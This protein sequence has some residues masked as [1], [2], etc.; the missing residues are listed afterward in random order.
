MGDR[1]WGRNYHF[2]FAW[3]FLVNGLVYV[4][5][6]VATGRFRERLV[7]RRD[8]LSRREP[9]GGIVRA[10][11]PWRLRARAAATSYGALQKLSYLLLLV[12]Y[13]PLMTLTGLAQSPGFTAAMP[14]LLD[15]FGGRQSARTLHTVGTV[16][17]VLFVVVHVRGSA[18]GRRRQPHPCDDHRQ[19]PVARGGVMSKPTAA[20][21]RPAR[22]RTL[23]RRRL[24]VQVPALGALMAAG[25]S[26][27]VYVPPRTSAG[28]PR[29]RR[30]R[31]H[32]EHEPAAAPRPAAGP[33]VRAGGH[34]P[35]LSDVGPDQ[36]RRRRAYQRHRREGFRDWRL[37]VG[38]LVGPAD[39]RSRSTTFGGCRRARRS[40]PTSASRGG[41]PSPSGPARPCCGCSRRRAA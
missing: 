4:G 18:G 11:L 7:P 5:W 31:A 40:P 36:P 15:M 2:T 3:V 39:A 21:R 1:R 28:R 32:H 9:R 24:L 27:D 20:P 26:R 41:R 37:P 13:V 22:P 17:F 34:R 33:R 12:V 30:R 38:G 14:W 8:E 29:G 10:H 19:V 16:V 23:S 35:R 25:C 6:N